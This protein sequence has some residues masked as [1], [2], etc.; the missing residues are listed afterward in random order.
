MSATGE[1]RVSMTRKSAT[2]PL[3]MNILE[4][5]M[6]YLSPERVALVLIPATSLPAEGSVT[7]MPMMA[8]PLFTR[9]R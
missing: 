1:V 3:V 8:S 2:W 6:M 9:G 5:L 7:A 4:P